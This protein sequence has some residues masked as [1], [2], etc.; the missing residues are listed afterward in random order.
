MRPLACGGESMNTA[1]QLLEQALEALIAS[2]DDV[3]TAMHLVPSYKADLER[4]VAEATKQL[5]KH[6]STIKD[7]E[8]HLA[9]Q[10]V[11]QE[12]FCYVRI[13]KYKFGW[14]P[15]VKEDA[16]SFALYTSP[17][18]RESMSENEIKNAR[19]AGIAHAKE[20]C[21]KVL[22]EED[23][24]LREAAKIRNLEIK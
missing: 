12:P 17:Q 2:R 13:D 1:T 9:K 21:A 23:F 16:G 22:E 8:A 4:R 15:C 10:Q 3:A 24:L 11:E 5:D 7:I 18:T 6:E 19:A 14:I 20:E